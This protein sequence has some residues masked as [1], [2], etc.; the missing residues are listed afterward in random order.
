MSNGTVTSSNRR[1]FVI[2]LDGA[3][4][5][6]LGPWMAE[7]H[8]P[9][10][11]KL[12]EA[13][14]HAPLE[15]SY[16]PI[17]GPAW[18]S[19]ITGKSPANNG[20]MEF[21]R[22]DPESYSLVLN[23]R[24]DIDGESIWGVLSRA[25]KQVGVIGVPLTWPPEAVNGF[26][27]TGLLTP[28]RDDVVFTHP[29]E[30]GDELHRALNGYLLQ[31]T[32]KYVQDD[33]MRLAHEERAILENKIDAVCYL[34]DH[35]PWDFFMFHLLGGDVLQHGFWQYMDPDHP[36]YT[37]ENNRKYGHVIPDYYKRLDER[38]P[39]V[40]GR[41]PENTYIAVMS[42]HGFGPLKK[43]INFNTWLLNKGF[44]K[45]RRNFWSQLRYFAFRLGYHYRLAW[46]IGSRTGLVRLI[47]KMGRGAQ[48]QAQR[49]MF[50]SL[51]D[52]DWSRSTVYSIGNFGQMYVN[53]K[54]RE[55]QGSV[56]PGE[57]FERTLQR[58][59]AELRTLRDPETGE[60]VVDKIWRGSEI[61]QGRYAH[62]AP[63]LFYFTKGYKY[64]A[65]GLSDFGS[66]QVFESLYGTHAHHHLHGIFMLSG[67]EIKVNQEIQVPNIVDLAPTIYHLQHVPIPSDLDGKVLTEAFTGDLA[68]RAPVFR[69]PDT[70]ESH[71]PKEG[72]NTEDEKNLMKLLK[73]LGYV[74]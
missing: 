11:R 52:V 17:T 70:S 24:N 5:D 6:L 56:E 8:L 14:V 30:L 38:L 37:A 9:N 73:D 64:K 16:P 36:E 39:E 43:Y 45:I 7:G 31:H 55:P 13:G 32:E 12:Y 23:S 65:M 1:V 34:L 27:V 10:L 47:I 53:L 49:K 2:A 29:P 22:R 46:E 41:L 33:P 48:E 62:L 25:G 51:D 59:E 44:L 74:N 26:L 18:A 28:R 19:F 57:M 66:N 63:D 42:D 58:L 50:L 20:V 21:F 69:E 15:S 35:K 3:T 72:F 54:G 67:P 68:A 40:L 71:P 60:E 4:Y 61:W